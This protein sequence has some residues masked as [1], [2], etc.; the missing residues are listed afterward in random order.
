MC[1][2][3]WAPTGVHESK[4]TL[5]DDR[6]DAGGWGRVTGEA[7]SRWR[8][9]SEA[10]KR[11]IVAVSYRSGISVSAV[12]RRHGVHASVLFKWRRRQ[13]KP[14]DS[15]AGFVPV[16]VE[17]GEVASEAPTGRMEIVLGDDVRVVVDATVYAPALPRVRAVVRPR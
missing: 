13:G 9:W 3:K 1:D 7:D 12:A 8:P 16:V 10:H 17:T 14:T 6:R 15:G 2:W 11:R 4:D 5:A